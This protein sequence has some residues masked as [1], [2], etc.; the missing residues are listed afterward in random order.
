MY[1][2]LITTK[3]PSPGDL[4]EILYR[5]SD[6]FDTVTVLYEDFED[7]MTVASSLINRGAI[8]ILGKEK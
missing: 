3:S 8:V 2:M 7:M 1:F 4:S 5:N 6:K